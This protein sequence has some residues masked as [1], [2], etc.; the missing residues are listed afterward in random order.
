MGVIT[1]HQPAGR[2]TVHIV[3][4]ARGRAS[5]IVHDTAELKTIT[6]LDWTARWSLSNGN[7]IGL[8]RC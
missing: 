5:K 1:Q 8:F 4:A 3:R 6:G 7:N 2:L